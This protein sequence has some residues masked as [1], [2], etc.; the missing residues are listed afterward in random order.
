MCHYLIG[1]GYSAIYDPF[2]IPIPMLMTHYNYQMKATKADINMEF[3]GQT[4][5]TQLQAGDKEAIKHYRQYVEM[6]TRPDQ[7]K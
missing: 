4:L 7:I 1:K 3:Q 2:E 6:L 5:L